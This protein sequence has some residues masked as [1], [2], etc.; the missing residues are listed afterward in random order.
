MLK[1]R[2]ILSVLTF[3]INIPQKATY[4]TTFMTFYKLCAPVLANTTSNQFFGKVFDNRISR[5]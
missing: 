4:K 3:L 2:R 5:G 1:H